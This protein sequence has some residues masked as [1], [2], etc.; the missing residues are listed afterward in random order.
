MT[1]SEFVTALFAAPKRVSQLYVPLRE[2]KES[3]PKTLPKNPAQ[4]CNIGGKVQ[5][6][7]KAGQVVTYGPAA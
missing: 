3:V 4:K 2:I 1:W 7:L 6:T 5:L